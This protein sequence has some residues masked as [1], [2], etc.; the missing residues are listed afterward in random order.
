MTPID[1]HSLNFFSKSIFN[2]SVERSKFFTVEKIDASSAKSLVLQERFFDK[3][4]LWI[5][6]NRDPK[7][8]P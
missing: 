3:S 4:S 8:E 1:E 7:T 6:K 5:R 2:W